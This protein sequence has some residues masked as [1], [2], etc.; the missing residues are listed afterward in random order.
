MDPGWGFTGYPKG[1]EKALFPRCTKT[2]LKSG[3]GGLAEPVKQVNNNFIIEL[4]GW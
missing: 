2:G 1:L 3:F 4:P